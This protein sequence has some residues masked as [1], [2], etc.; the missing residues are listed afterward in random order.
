MCQGEPGSP[1]VCRPATSPPPDDRC[2]CRGLRLFAERLAS[3]V[4]GGIG[5][6]L[7]A[8]LMQA[9]IDSLVGLRSAALQPF[10]GTHPLA[11]SLGALGGGVAL[12]VLTA[13]L[14]QFVA[15]RAGGGGV[16]LLMA[17]LNGLNI[18]GRC[19]LGC[20]LRWQPRP[21]VPCWP[22]PPFHP[23]NKLCCVHAPNHCQH[24]Q[25]CSPFGCGPSSWWAASSLGSAA[26]AWGWKVSGGRTGGEG[27][28]AS[29]EPPGRGWRLGSALAQAGH[30][31][32]F[33]VSCSGLMRSHSVVSCLGR[34]RLRMPKWGWEQQELKVLIAIPPPHP[35]LVRRGTPR[36]QRRWSCWVQS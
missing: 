21:L 24:P 29:A 14:V 10:M 31:R 27:W 2:P 15:P 6:G 28:R 3:T 9:S 19:Q 33:G 25:I 26:C 13:A 16:T 23:A 34:R 11:V 20:Q 35:H 30:R 17:Y 12:V 22:E 7:T 32:P 5:V 4:L 8:I 18:P 1:L 36:L